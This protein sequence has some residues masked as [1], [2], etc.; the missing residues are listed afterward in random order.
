M[1]FREDLSSGYFHEIEKMLEGG[2]YEAHFHDPLNGLFDD[3]PIAPVSC[4][5][6][7]WTDVDTEEDIARAE[8]V[9]KKIQEEGEREG[10]K[11]VEV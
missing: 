6:W 2:Q 5:D 1:R 10:A 7:S 3:Y 11:L 8:E 9:L 4:G